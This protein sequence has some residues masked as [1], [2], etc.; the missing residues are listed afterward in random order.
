MQNSFLNFLFLL[1]HKHRSKHI[2]VFLI[3]TLLVTLL[4]S[5]MFLSTSLK[6]DALAALHEQPDFT[7]QK[8]EAGRSVD[9]PV[10]RIDTFSDI[11][12]VS[13]VAPRVFGRYFTPD[14]KRYF[15]IIGIDFF[16]EQLVRWIAKL[17]KKI[18][19]KAFLQKDQMIVGNAV[20][21]Y[22][23]AHYYD[24]YFNFITPEGKEKKV[25]IYKTL[26]QNSNL[27]SSDFILMD[28]NLAR[29][30]LGVA[31]DKA[32]DII[33]NV[34]NPA[35]RD[36]VKF[37]LLSLNYDTRIITKK[38]L[39][40]TYEN[41]FNYKGGVFLLGFILS[42]ITFML[43]LFQR[44]AIIN[45]TEKKEIAIL[46]A[47]GWSIKDVIRLKISETLVI[48]LF[49]FL[50]G[51]IVAYFYVFFAQAPLLRE[52][53]LGFGNLENSVHLTPVI[54][55]GMLSSMFFFF[56]VPFVTSVLIPVWKIAITDAG[57]ALK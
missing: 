17:Y 51:V 56:I 2:A 7:V 46:R 25:Y 50:I 47:V 42:L 53:F 38:E 14:T 34:P 33:L 15:T 12:G 43:I 16:D 11:K 44:Y 26:P 37:K 52:I 9:I 30:I 23:K 39:Q 49:A 31:P 8:L 19:I 29:E 4:A 36:N 57:E 28:I 21:K 5:F 54:D 48:A 45:S 24:T 27:I 20:M 55:F 10:S 35:E 41:L 1:V 18:D 3:A 6:H 22:M 40:K 13:Y 32:T